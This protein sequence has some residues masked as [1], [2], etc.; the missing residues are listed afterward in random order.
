MLDYIEE[1]DPMQSDILLVI[2]HKIMED[3]IEAILS[4]SDEFRVVGESRDGADALTLCKQLQPQLV[5]MKIDLPE[6]NAF[7]ATAEIARDCPAS[8]VIILSAYD[9]ECS[10]VTAIR[11]GARAFVLIRDLDPDLLE[12]LRVVAKGGSYL[13]PAVCDRLISRLKRGD[14]D[15]KQHPQLLNGLSKRELELLRLTSEGR[16]GRQIALLFTL[17]LENVRNLLHAS[18]FPK[19]NR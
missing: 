12:A 11:S 19:K 10:V 14:F 16:T 3:A 18:S 7:E 5:L 6:L 13:S 4:H 1:R 15:Y 17:C 8:K 2:D 9:D